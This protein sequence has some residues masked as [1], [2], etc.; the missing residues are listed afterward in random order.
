MAPGEEAR[1]VLM[2]YQ[3]SEANIFRVHGA[4]TISERLEM[5]ATRGDARPLSKSATHQSFI[6]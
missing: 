1:R 3:P 5:L 4:L 2:K 6:G